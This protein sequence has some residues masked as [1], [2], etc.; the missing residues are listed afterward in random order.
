MME[1]VLYRNQLT[2]LEMPLK[3]P[4]T[5][6]YLVWHR[7]MNKDQGHQWLRQLILSC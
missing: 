2:V 4:T 5:P 1:F 6:F 3:L 7:A